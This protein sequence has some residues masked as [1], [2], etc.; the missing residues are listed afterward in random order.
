V[1]LGA[2]IRLGQD[3]IIGGLGAGGMGEVYRSRDTRL[4]REVAIK[5]ILE[6][7]AADRDPS[8]GSGSS[9]VTPRRSASC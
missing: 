8:T 5:V 1:T 6:A 4:G 3:E 2:G 7:F 9:R